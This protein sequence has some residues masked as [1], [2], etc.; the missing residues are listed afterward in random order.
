MTPTSPSALVPLRPVRALLTVGFTEAWSTRLL[1]A[2]TIGL[3]AAF[4]RR[5][6]WEASL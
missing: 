4:A 3:P 6:D 2:A 5:I 1:C